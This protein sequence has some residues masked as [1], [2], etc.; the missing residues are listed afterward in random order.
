MG[1]ARGTQA[2]AAGADT[3]TARAADLLERAILAGEL[4]PG[5]RLGIADLA[6]H[7]EIGATPLREALSRLLSSGL[8]VGIGQRGFRVAE[9]SHADLHDLTRMRAVVEAEAL[10]L[11]MRLG[12]DRWEA[13]IVAALHRL[14]RRCARAGSAFREGSED[15]DAIHKAFHRALLNACGSPRLLAAHSELYDQ[16]YR[17]RRVMM[18][19]FATPETFVANHDRLATAVLAR[20]PAAVDALVGHLELTV[21]YVYPPAED[22]VS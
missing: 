6:Q 12:D 18:Q 16:A 10:R 7:Y 15:F 8:I 4:A 9:L 13:D 21:R 11:S 3:L 1:T 14:Q 22:R 20:D 19:A 2:E 17:Y 5:T